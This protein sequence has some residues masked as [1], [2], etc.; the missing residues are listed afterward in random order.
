MIAQQNVFPRERPSFKR[1]V[2]VLR[3]PDD[4][5]RVDRQLRGMEH[6]SVMLFN[7]SHAFKDHHYGAPFGAHVDGLKGCVK[8]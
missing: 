8:H 7:A 6:V 4:G 1:N 3:Q 5:R 2:D